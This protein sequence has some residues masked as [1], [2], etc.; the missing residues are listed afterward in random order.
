M[1]ISNII[2]NT[3]YL[4][5]VLSFISCGTNKQVATENTVVIEK[6][7]TVSKPKIIFFNFQIEK[8]EDKKSIS[9]INQIKAEGKLKGKAKKTENKTVGDLEYILLDNNLT[10]IEKHVIKNPLKKT[11][12]FVNDFGSFEKKSLD[13]NSAQFTIRMQL[14]PEA[15]HIA[16]T[17]LTNAEPIKHITIKIN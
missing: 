14:P 10:E 6:I 1:K 8:L 13:L 16:I 5:L 3:F 9:L 17:E 7:T 15:R 12:E 4:I 2:K 11:V